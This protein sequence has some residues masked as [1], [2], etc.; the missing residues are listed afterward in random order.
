MPALDL[1]TTYYPRGYPDLGLEGRSLP[2]RWRRDASVP[3]LIERV[4][5]WEHDR[6]LNSSFELSIG[7]RIPASFAFEMAQVY[8]AMRERFPSVAPEAVHV[9]TDVSD[10]TLAYAFGYAGDFPMLRS[11]GVEDLDS[12]DIDALG[13]DL[14]AVDRRLLRA[15]YRRRDG[16]RNPMT[17]GTIDISSV[18]GSQR[19][20]RDLIVFWKRRNARAVI[21]ERPVRMPPLA[22]S[23]ATMVLVHEFGHLVDAELINGDIDAAR[24]VYAALSACVFGDWPHSE[25]QWR[26]H[27]WNYPTSASEVAGAVQG[28]ARRRHANRQALRW[29]LGHALTRYAAASRDEA[30]AEAFALTFCADTAQR[31]ALAPF[32][33]ALRDVGM[34]RRPPRRP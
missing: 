13:A 28:G 32:R 22:T 4:E 19:R 17:A 15:E 10:D 18:F 1:D 16:A 8:V 24:Y 34:L 3:A 23:P 14:D 21:N 5:R 12:V 31:R 20:Y 6:F 26:Y 9:G 33:R 11:L 2:L 27:L 30:F 7:R 25:R 29:V